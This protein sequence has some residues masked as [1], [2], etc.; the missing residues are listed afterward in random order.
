MLWLSKD[1]KLSIFRPLGTI[2]GG[3]TGMFSVSVCFC[4]GWS[5]SAWSSSPWEASGGRTY[6]LSGHTAPSVVTS[7]LRGWPA[8]GDTSAGS[9]RRLSARRGEPVMETV[10]PQT[11]TSTS[12]LV[13]EHLLL[14]NLVESLNVCYNDGN[15]QV[16]P[17]LRC[18]DGQTMNNTT[19]LTW[20]WCP[21]W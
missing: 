20:W 7:R 8:C 9:S 21:A 11:N 14:R 17:R 4:S 18:C 19:I 2:A 13:P 6:T 15:N 3:L 1:V 5:P 10:S 12:N 16:Y